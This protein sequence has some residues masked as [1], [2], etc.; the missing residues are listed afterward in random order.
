MKPVVRARLTRAAPVAAAWVVAFAPLFAARGALLVAPQAMIWI[1]LA[2]LLGM[3]AALGYAVRK[4]V[5]RLVRQDFGR[6]LA[7]VAAP[8]AAISAAA[9]GL[10]SPAAI[11]PAG[12]V[13]AVAW[14]R[15][16]REAGLAATLSVVAL[17]GLDL[18]L[19]RSLLVGGAFLSAAA[20]AG[21]GI[22]P[23]W[24]ARRTELES[25]R[26]RQRIKRLDVFLRDRPLT[27]RGSNI[28]A[29]DLRK[30]AQDA[31]T[32]ADAM[33]QMAILDRY[34]RDVRDGM[35]AD[36]VIFWKFHKSADAMQAT[37]WSTEGAQGPI[38]F[39]IQDWGPLVQW[40]A[41]GEVVHCD[42]ADILAHLVAGPV[43]VEPG[44]LIGAISA[45]SARG[46]VLSR[47]ELRERMARAAAHVAQ[48]RVLLE[49][50]GE[51]HRLRR[52]GDALLLAVQQIQAH[53][54]TESLAK[55]ICQTALDITEGSV[56]TL[57]RWDAATRSGIVEAVS[58]GGERSRGEKVTFDCL[59]GGACERGT[60]L[61]MQDAPL[62]SGIRPGRWRWLHR[63]A[64]GRAAHARETRP[65]RRRRD[66]RKPGPA[67]RGGCSQRQP[68][69]RSGGYFARDGVADR[70]G[71]P[72]G[73]H[74]P[75]H[76]I[77]EPP[78]L[79]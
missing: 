15:G 6:W 43:M 13:L 41:E 25:K 73:Q 39:R 66:R 76:R 44:K 77:V 74:R 50:R 53:T 8:I 34:L 12:V 17:A 72:A 24:A 78:S 79:R 38:H 48:L 29:S 58:A 51:H 1:A 57:V 23:L 20:I 19:G 26:A 4:Q 31:S 33:E 5:P 37:A 28:V 22:L 60:R 2:T 42:E 3:L 7:I 54:S 65:R 71:Q 68:V 69:R 67:P 9:G 61:S 62:R 70:G 75:A 47:E 21:V 64:G 35:G 40:S 30:S 55:G 46:F 56:A 27:P 49:H 36:E 18:M 16:A 45:T 11:L 59:V 10:A 14:K 32:E 52:R 63:L